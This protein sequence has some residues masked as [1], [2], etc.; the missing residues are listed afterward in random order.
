MLKLHCG[1]AGSTSHTPCVGSSFC[2]NKKS[3]I[4]GVLTDEPKD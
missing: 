1:K 3:D 2:S 4:H